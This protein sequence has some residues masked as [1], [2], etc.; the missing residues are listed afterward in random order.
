MGFALNMTASVEGQVASFC[1]DGNELS[2]L[3][4]AEHRVD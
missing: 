4:R 1:E 3:M 2:G